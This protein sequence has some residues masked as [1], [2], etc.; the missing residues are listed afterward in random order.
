MTARRASPAKL[1][2]I[3][4]VV[5]CVSG[6]NYVAFKIGLETIPPLMMV[7]AR[8][9][10]AGLIFLPFTFRAD[11]P[12]WRQF[13]S[14][15]TAGLLL[16]VL[17]QGGIVWGVQY[18][19]VGI[20]ALVG[21]SSPIWVALFG[22]IL[23]RVRSSRI[24]MAGILCGIAGLALLFTPDGDA[25]LDLGGM[26]AVLIGA[27]SWALGS[28]YVQQADMPESAMLCSCWEML[29]A[30][31]MML[32]CVGISGELS[33]FHPHALSVRSTV[34]FLFLVAIGSTIGFGGII[35]LMRNTT[36]SLANT[37]NYVAPVVAMMLGVSLFE[38]VLTWRDMVAAALA[39]AGVVLILLSHRSTGQERV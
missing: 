30:G 15:G 17:G 7:A 22:R 29:I 35:W 1:G 10:L 16:L 27:M 13:R 3:L 6:G 18:L 33:A 36:P 37:F 31:V 19:P 32:A 12:S 38:E 2:V 25:A 4:L 14:L 28:L 9:L 34:A 24:E 39:L 23:L 8:S 11:W 21:S 20:A 5:W 26:A